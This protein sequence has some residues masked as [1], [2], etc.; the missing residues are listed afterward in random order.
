[1][2]TNER[3]ELYLAI[4]ATVSA[5]ATL[6][7]LI[8]DIPAIAQTPAG[9][10]ILVLVF[11]AAV[12]YIGYFIYTRLLRRLFQL[13]KSIQE[14]RRS[15][16]DFTSRNSKT[17]FKVIIDPDEI[18][19]I[20]KSKR[21]KSLL[22]SVQELDRIADR[23]IKIVID[24]GDNDGLLDAMQFKVFHNSRM[25]EIGLCACTPFER[26][27][28]LVIQVDPACPIAMS[29]ITRENVEVRLIEPEPSNKVNLL[30]ANLLSIIDYE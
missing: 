15:L 24:K 7:G 8:V 12:G 25:H 28:T 5:V 27:T 4:L 30:L 21:A 20:Q 17:E 3:N 13:Q 26:E 18:K 11:L 6:I 23:E 10:I 22:F 29:E 2:K 16:V 9:Q 19:L 1:M 14:I